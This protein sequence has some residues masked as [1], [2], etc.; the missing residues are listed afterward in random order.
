MKKH[1]WV[2]IT[3]ETGRVED[4]YDTRNEAR[5]NC[6]NL[7]EVVVRGEVTGKPGK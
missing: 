7:E 4:I 2:I 1:F 6:W 3:K 5:Q